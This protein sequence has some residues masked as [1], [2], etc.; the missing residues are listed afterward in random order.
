MFPGERAASVVPYSERT[1]S[2]PPAC[3]SI[4]QQYVS[5]L[6]EA[7]EAAAATQ[8]QAAPKTDG[9]GDKTSDGKGV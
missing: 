9:G 2:T 3:R 4:P 7:A 1:A 5:R 6:E 8:E